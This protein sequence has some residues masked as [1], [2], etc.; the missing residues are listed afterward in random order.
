M[1]RRAGLIHFFLNHLILVQ[2]PHYSVIN[3]LVQ[4]IHMCIVN[5]GK[6]DFFVRLKIRDTN[7][8]KKGF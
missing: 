5:I 6:L 8:M 4:F 2:T 3:S 1:A 7:H